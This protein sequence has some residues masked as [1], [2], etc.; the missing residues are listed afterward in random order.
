MI[1]K[2]HDR[3]TVSSEEKIQKTDNTQ[4]LETARVSGNMMITAG[5]IEI[6]FGILAM[7][8]AA[9][10]GVVFTLLLGSVMVVGGIIEVIMSISRNNLA[11]FA[12]GLISLIAGVFV[13][14]HPLFGL[15]FLTMLVGIYLAGT[16]IA[17][18]FGKDRPMWTRIAGAF[19]IILSL[20][21]FASLSTISAVLIGLLVGLNILLDG[22]ITMRVGTDIKQSV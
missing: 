21:V 10:T 13:I 12:V 2:E 9:L 15:N 11:R 8:L 14:A 17:R 4:T 5:V 7:F 3:E 20:I 18:L 6:I 16:G 1:T 22:I 19:G